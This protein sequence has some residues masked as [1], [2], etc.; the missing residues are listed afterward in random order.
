MQ[1]SPGVCC[2]RRFI[3]KIRQLIL[4][5]G[6]QIFSTCRDPADMSGLR[7]LH[8]TENYVLPHKFPLWLWRLDSVG[9][10]SKLGEDGAGGDSPSLQEEAAARLCAEV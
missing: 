4:K 8:F 5:I 3:L 1:W 9:F 10:C 6:Q 2:K 7:K